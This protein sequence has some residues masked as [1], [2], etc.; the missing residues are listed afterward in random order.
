MSWRRRPVPVKRWPWERARRACFDRDG[1]RCQACQR[2]GR[3]E[4]HHIVALED[5]G[6]PYA[7]GN[8]RTLCRG[9]HIELHRSERDPERARW[10]AVVA[11]LIPLR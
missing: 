4:A 7:L 1:W 10:K 3:L 2:A 11:E 6:K 8:L 5:G 9:C